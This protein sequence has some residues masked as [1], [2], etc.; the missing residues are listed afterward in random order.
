M[1]IW[2]MFAALSALFAVLSA[3]NF[4]RHNRKLTIA[5]RVWLRIAILYAAVVLFLIFIGQ[6]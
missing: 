5:A 2:F 4:F 6:D 3:R 1:R